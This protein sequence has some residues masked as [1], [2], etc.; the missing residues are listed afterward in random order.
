M[1][2]QK[3]NPISLDGFNKLMQEYRT[4][5]E[6]RPKIVEEVSLAARQ[7]DRSENAEYIYGKRRLRQIDGRM[8]FLSTRMEAARVVNP[9][10]QTGSIIL[11]G[12]TVT[13][14]NEQGKSFVWQILGEDEVDVSQGKISWK[15]PLGRALIKKEI[16]EE[17]EVET[18]RGP[19]YYRIVHFEFK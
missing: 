11:F 6:E 8:H 7:G 3:N 15:S 18:P 9:A 12:A 5:G 1:A 2:V 16:N 19:A 13:L 17:V 4:L 10:E 14:E